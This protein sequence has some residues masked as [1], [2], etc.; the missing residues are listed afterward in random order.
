MTISLSQVLAFMFPGGVPLVDWI[1]RNDDDGRGEF[2]YK[3]LRQEP[4]PTPEEIDA[5]R[6]S[7]AVDAVARLI[8]AERDRRDDLPVLFG[9]DRIQCDRRRLLDL[10]LFK[11]IGAEAAGLIWYTPTWKAIPMSPNDVASVTKTWVTRAIATA[12]VAAG[13]ITAAAQSD[14]P[15]S[16]DF[17]KNW[18]E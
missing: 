9:G 18:P 1:I 5:A 11:S 14:D 12:K 16:Y 15:L 3:W 6:H 4:Q 13:H 7:A 17:S 8:A 2:I 10:V